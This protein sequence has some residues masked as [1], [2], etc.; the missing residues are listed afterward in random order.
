MTQLDLLFNNYETQ[1]QLV[2]ILDER[3][4]TAQRNIIMADERLKTG[5]ISSLD[6]Q[7]IQLS[8]LN[9]SFSRISAIYN[10][11]SIKTDIAFLV[12]Q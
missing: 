3:L 7:N 9:I 4:K 11:L 1:L 6:Y 8:Y 12:A 2:G 5:A 10:L